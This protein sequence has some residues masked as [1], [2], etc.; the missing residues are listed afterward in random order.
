MLG[1]CGKER[2]KEIV[3]APK[4]NLLVC[5]FAKNLGDKQYVMNI[6]LGLCAAFGSLF[7]F[8]TSYREKYKPLR[9]E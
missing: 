1:R 5:G 3:R 8:Y 7:H 9:C 4:S 2:I 6:I